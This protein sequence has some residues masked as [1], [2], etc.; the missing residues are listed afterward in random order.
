MKTK[1]D[2]RIGMAGWVYEPW[3]GTFYPEGLAQKMELEFA[4]RQVNSIELNGSFYS[5]QRP[6]SFVRWHAETPEDFRFSI[7]GSRYITHIRRL[8]NVEEPLARFFSQ[9]LLRLGPK[10]GPVLWQFPPSLKFDA[11][12]FEDFFALLPRSSSAAARLGRTH[13]AWADGRS[14]NEDDEDREI[15]HAVEVRHKSFACEEYIE[16]LRQYSVALVV[17]DTPKW[18]LLFDLTADFVYCRLHGSEQIYTSGYDQEA[19]KTW[20]RRVVAWSRGEEVEDG[21]KASK[22]HAGKQSQ[23]D[24]FAYF[25]NDLKVRAPADAQSLHREVEG[26]L[27]SKHTSAPRQ[28]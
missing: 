17:A 15:R 28:D 20:A 27:A 4:S 19:I 26:L 5:L 11:Q 2:I 22:K 9:G 7:K 25:D 14:G 8:K 18:P 21:D 3:R 10:L 24:V 16:L 1:A 23:R 13:D 6:E 12:T